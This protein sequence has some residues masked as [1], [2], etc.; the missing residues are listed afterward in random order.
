MTKKLSIYQ[1]QLLILFL[2]SMN[3]VGRFF[4]LF[5]IAFLITCFRYRRNF[6]VNIFVVLAAICGLALLLFSPES[7]SMTNMIKPFVY[8]MC[9]CIGANILNYTD[10]E[11]SEKQFEWV[12]FVMAAGPFVHLMLN[13]FYN[14]NSILYRNT[15]DIWS[16]EP[17]GATGQAA[18]GV[19]AVAIAI[20]FVLS[21]G[22]KK[23]HIA[24]W[25]ILVFVL[26]Y[27]LV[28]A[29]R[30]LIVIVL[31]IFLCALLNLVIMS[32]NRKSIL[33]IT[34]TTIVCI[35]TGY[36]LYSFNVFGV[37][38]TIE[39]STLYARFFSADAT[40]KLDQDS[41]LDNKIY[42]L[43]HLDMAT[44]GGCHIRI[45]NG[46]HYAHDLL[47]DGFDEGGILALIALVAM[48]VF[49]IVVLL[50]YL[51]SSEIDF[52]CKQLVLCVTAA[53]YLEFMIEPILAGY[54]WFFA[55]FC[56]IVSLFYSYYKKTK[57]GSYVK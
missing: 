28:L 1:L 37:K 46:L 13:M 57:G 2:A 12:I 39:N 47:L 3:F 41:R 53:F 5:V 30:T 23:K 38:S 16:K 29:G 25:S 45:S 6:S 17:M 40:M 27:N 19:I 54:Q 8:A 52:N 34:I 48:L 36:F 11:I 14:R 44:W 9:A 24:G 31:I 4:Y 18:L 7:N 21:E 55:E 35:V 50:K 43:N 32:K 42:F 20:A 22:S 26:L 56:F 15:L 51:F 33:K 49:S 10:D